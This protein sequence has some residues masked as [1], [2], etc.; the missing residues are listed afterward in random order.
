[1]NKSLKFI[2]KV[3]DYSIYFFSYNF[4]NM[5]CKMQERKRRILQVVFLF[6]SKVHSLSNKKIRLC[7]LARSEIIADATALGAGVR[8]GAHFFKKTEG[9]QY[10][11]SGKDYRIKRRN[12]EL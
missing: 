9:N 4:Y 12:R 5:T 2:K 8:Q 1:M 10:G 3:V 6:D 7:A 11:I